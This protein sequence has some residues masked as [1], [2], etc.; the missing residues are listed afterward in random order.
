MWTYKYAPLE[1]YKK[2]SGFN[3]LAIRHQVTKSKFGVERLVCTA[4]NATEAK[5][6]ARAMNQVEREQYGL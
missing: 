3:V 4:L 1:M 5:Q 2:K 6:I